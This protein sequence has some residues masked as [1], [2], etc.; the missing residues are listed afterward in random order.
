MQK[1]EIASLLARHLGLTSYL[2][3]CTPTTGFTYELIDR[4]QLTRTVRLMYRCPPEFS[5]GAALDLRTPAE[6]AEALYASLMRAGERFDL[7]F[8]DPWHTYASS[9]RDLVFALQL[10]K[11]DGVVMVHDCNPPHA[12]CARPEF[13]PGEWCGVTFGAFL[14]VV[15]FARRLSYFTVDADYGCGVISKNERLKQRFAFR[16]ENSH[17]AS[18]QPLGLTEKYAL[19]ES[20][21]SELLHLIS[22]DEFRQRLSA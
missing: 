7:V 3:I 14:D 21:R 1:Y 13:Q 4:E 19:L 6:S 8:V 9:L 12:A 15:L 20:A 16:H 22:P 11:D 17:A 18:W 10:V 5:D 2:E